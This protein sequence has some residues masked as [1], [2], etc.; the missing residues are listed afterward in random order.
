MSALAA[1]N[2]DG[3]VLLTETAKFPTLF[4]PAPAKLAVAVSGGADSM[5]LVL[6][7]QQWAQEEGRSIHAFTVDHGLRQE[8]ADEATQVAAWMQ[9][10][11]IPHRILRWQPCPA[12][13]ANRQDAARRARYTLLAEACAAKGIDHLLLGHHRDDQAETLLLRLK[14]GSHLPGL[15]C[16]QPISQQH[17]LTL[18]R[19]LL[20]V[21]R[22]ELRHYL[23]TRQQDWLEDP[24]NADLRYDRSAARVLLRSLPQ[25][26]SQQ[27][28]EATQQIGQLAQSDALLLADLLKQF[29]PEAPGRYSIAQETLHATPINLAARALGQV[30]QRLAGLDYPPRHASLERAIHQLQQLG[31][32]QLG[33]CNL[34]LAG[35]KVT[36]ARER[37]LKASPIHAIYE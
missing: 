15:A 23:H 30:I 34:T 7:V 9:A 5:A 24:S 12:P 16:M 19:P 6:L 33:G 18:I 2:P 37:R 29:S 10:H 14:R 26:T 20:T 25:D 21:P 13:T 3:A 11:T 32:H 8:S 36:I 1:N 17:G 35:H 4:P 27:L 31:K 22:A 28:V